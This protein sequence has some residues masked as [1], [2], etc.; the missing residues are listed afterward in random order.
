MGNDLS[1]F[2]RGIPVIDVHEHHM[3]DSLHDREVGLLQLLEESYCEWTRRRPYP[4]PSEPPTELRASA[5]G[6]GTW[7]DIAGYVE[8]SGTNAFVRNMTRALSELYGPE[9]GALDERGWEALDE[10]IRR[11]HADPAWAGTVLARA[12]VETVITDPYRDPLLDARRALGEGYRSVLRI[13]ALALG[14]HPE[15]RDHNGNSAHEL[16]ARCGLR[17]GSFDDY[18][19]ALA[20]LLDAMPGRHQVGLKNALAYDRALQFDDL[21]VEAA[22]RAWGVRRPAEHERKAFGDV[23]V[24]RLCRLAGER[25]IPVQM[26]LGTG[27]MRGSSPLAAAGLIERHPRTRFLLMHLAYPWSGELF[28][29]A[30]VHRNVWI[31]LTWSWLLSPT[32]FRHSFA[33][34]VDV[35]PDES[36]MMLGGDAWHVEESYGAIGAARALIAEVLGE[37]VAEGRFG[38]RDAERLAVKI[39]HDNAAGFFGLKARLGSPGSSAPGTWGRSRSARSRPARPGRGTRTGRSSRNPCAAWR[40]A[41]GWPGCG[42]WPRSPSGCRRCPAARSRAGSRAA[43]PARCRSRSS[44]APGRRPGSR[45]PWTRRSA[46]RRRSRRGRLPRRPA[47][48]RPSWWRSRPAPAGPAGAPRPPCPTHARFVIEFLLSILPTSIVAGAAER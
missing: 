12:G 22:R 30:F 25:D 31:D 8:G 28:G 10:A 40:T 16:L 9:G 2:I 17:P 41:P 1:A 32:R 11:R 24:D 37:G 18:L 14:W 42:R 19:E 36:R 43:R 7:G 5:K 29:L 47:R 35:L 27:L 6:R 33:E 26:H 13:N 21:D 46:G 48:S 44:P 3:P 34:A 20:A 15:A 39:L 38:R 45:S 4:L 23:V